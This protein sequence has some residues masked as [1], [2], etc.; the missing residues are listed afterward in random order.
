M[1]IGD[2]GR[3]E[4]ESKTKVFSLVTWESFHFDSARYHLSAMK[5]NSQTNKNTQTIKD[6]STPLKQAFE[7]YDLVLNLV[8]FNKTLLS[9][10]GLGF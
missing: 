6:E 4:E 1:R 3:I 7:K 9:T 8:S 5:L 2:K 10:R